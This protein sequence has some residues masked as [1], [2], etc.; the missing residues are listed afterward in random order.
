MERAK[1]YL[2][3]A[4]HGHSGSTLFEQ[5]LATGKS[6]LA[7]GEI[8]HFSSYFSNRRCGC[9]QALAQCPFWNEVVRHLALS[10]AKLEQALPTDGV[11]SKWPPANWAYLAMLLTQSPLLKVAEKIPGSLACLNRASSQSH[12]RLIDAAASMAKAEC[13]VD[14]SMSASRLLE[15][16]RTAPPYYRICA[17][18]LV[19]DGR[20]NVP[21]YKRNFK[22]PVAE[23]ARNWR[24]AN[25][26]IERVLKTLPSAQKMRIRYEDL[27][28]S[29]DDTLRQIAAT[30]DLGMTFDASKV[31][32]S[33]HAIGGN[34]GRQKK[35]YES[36]RA[37]TSWSNVLSREYVTIFGR[38]AGSLNSVYGYETS[39]T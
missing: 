37:D 18:H 1:A 7:V 16:R 4:C 34:Y 27:C 10:G 22:V 2:F 25:Q 3:I 39:A 21:S 20:A 15:L 19:R 13:V 5:L 9:G 23:A 29:P 17:I 28:A 6:V 30:F 38:V 26:N 12:W 11:R 36:V 35:G 8:A 14:K 33:N 32:E 31:G 24:A